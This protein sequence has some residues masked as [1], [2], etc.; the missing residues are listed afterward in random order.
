[1]DL[2]EVVQDSKE[3]SE[4]LRSMWVTDGIVDEGMRQCT[5]QRNHAQATDGSV[6]PQ[7]DQVQR[8]TS[9]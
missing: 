1:M 3:A 9:E 2:I 8:Q 5:P 4:A 6:R 7:N